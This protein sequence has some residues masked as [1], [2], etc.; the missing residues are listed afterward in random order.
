MKSENECWQV[1]VVISHVHFRR[2]VVAKDTVS[3]NMDKFLKIPFEYLTI[4]KKC[5]IL[6]L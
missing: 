1:L 2:F 3:T 4:T 6:L 5:G